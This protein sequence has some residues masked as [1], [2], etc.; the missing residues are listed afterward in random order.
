MQD[1]LLRKSQHY[2]GIHNS[3]IRPADPRRVKL[4]LG[5]VGKYESTGWN[6]TNKWPEPASTL[7][8]DQKLTANLVLTRKQNRTEIQS[9]QIGTSRES[10]IARERPNSLASTG[11]LSNRRSRNFTGTRVTL[12]Q[13]VNLCEDRQRE[14][15]AWLHSIPS[16]TW[17]FECYNFL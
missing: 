15:L 1:L 8:P 12:I 6:R 13:T 9:I 4:N 17:R 16:K 2:S 5:R 14:V 3:I 11:G 7:K 10:K